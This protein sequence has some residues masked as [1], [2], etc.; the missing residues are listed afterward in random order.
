MIVANSLRGWQ[1][2]TTL[3][4]APAV[5]WLWYTIKNWRSGGAYLRAMHAARERSRGGRRSV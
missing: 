3:L 4:L 2:G 1:L 5:I